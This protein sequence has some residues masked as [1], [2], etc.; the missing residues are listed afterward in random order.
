MNPI[1]KWQRFLF[2]LVLFLA[3]VGAACRPGTAEPVALPESGQAPMSEN[4]EVEPATP[5]NGEAETENGEL[6]GTL[7]ALEGEQWTV[8]G[9]I[10]VVDGQTELKGTFAPGDQVKVHTVARG[11]GALVLRE[12]EMVPADD[13]KS[14][15]DD[16]L[17]DSVGQDEA[18]AKEG[19][20]TGT[21]EQ[22]E[23]DRWT[24]GGQS[25]LLTDQTELEGGFASGDEVKV[26]FSARTD[27]TLVLR[28][29]EL[30]SPDGEMDDE[31]DDTDSH[32]EDRINRGTSNL[33]DNHENNADS[34][35]QDDQNANGDGGVGDDSSNDAVDDHL[36]NDSSDENVSGGS[37]E[38]DQNVDGDDDSEHESEEEDDDSDL[39]NSGEEHED[40]ED[41]GDGGH[42]GD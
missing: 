8:D 31:T 19:E 30:T 25:F 14:D 41:N 32:E 2:V 9:Q 35:L 10:F 33:T 40:R 22:I 42:H 39:Q 17:D 18:G 29:V 21:L 37:G 11:D 26:H 15:P 4:V 3:A 1:S 34:T 24:I 5:D 23:G 16:G 7:E 38:D 28:E 27:G 36:F 12:V 20:F 13:R 6:T